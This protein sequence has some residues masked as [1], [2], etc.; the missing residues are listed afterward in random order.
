LIGVEL[1]AKAREPVPGQ[2]PGLDD[3]EAVEQ[4]CLLP[5][6]TREQQSQL[7]GAAQ[8]RTLPHLALEDEQLLAERKDLAIA[9]VAEQAGEQGSKGARGE[10]NTSSRCQNMRGG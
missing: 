2:H 9:V 7:L 3:H 4:L 10:N 1:G 6:G 5:S 8:P